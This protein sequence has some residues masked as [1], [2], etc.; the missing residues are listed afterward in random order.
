MV[1][2]TLSLV[3]TLTQTAGV[4]LVWTVFVLVGQHTEQATRFFALASEFLK[5]KT[6]SSDF[7]QNINTEEEP[8]DKFYLAIYQIFRISSNILI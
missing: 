6:I 3:R 2:W 1:L 8:E 7:I 4:D 5:E